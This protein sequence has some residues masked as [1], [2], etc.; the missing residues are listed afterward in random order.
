MP[1]AWG[2]NLARFIMAALLTIAF[3]GTSRGASIEKLLMPGPL[4]AAHAKTEEQCGA[5]HDKT[6][7]ERQRTLCLACHK[8]IAE[9][10]RT[11]TGFHGRMPGAR[12]GQCAGCH[13]EHH[14]RGADVVNLDR[15]SF[16]HDRTNFPLSGAHAA[17]DCSGCHRA[18]SPFRK[19]P[20]AC[21]GCHRTDDAHHGNLG[22]DCKACH[23]ETA[24]QTVSFDHDRTQFPL[25]DKHREVPCSACHA[26]EHYKGTPREC[27]SCHMPDD[28]HRGSRGARCGDCHTEAGWKTAKFDHAKETGFPLLGRHARIGCADCH[29]TGNLKDPLPKTCSGCHA[30]DDHH[31]GR[32]G[33]DCASCHGNELW[34][35]EHYDHAGRHHFELTGAHA[36]LACESCHT[37]VARAQKLP[38]DC[39]GC[40]RADD[41]HGGALGKACDRCHAS[42]RWSE[43]I[44]FDHDLS[45]F[46]LVGLHIV[47]TCA[48]CHASQRFTDAPKD[49]N[50]CHA[51]DDVHKGSLGPQCADCHTPNGWKLWQFDHAAKTRFALTGA[52]ATLRCADC[53]VK[54]A[55]EMK[56]SR[57]CGSCH[58]GDDI[59]DGQFGRHCERCHN[60]ISF[61]GGRAN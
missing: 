43:R 17:V 38:T 32:F 39:A 22:T 4:S 20:V 54:P 16:D 13:S 29:R 8:D 7:R 45:D 26:G 24:W 10:L 52:H 14:G 23:R 36:E 61:R 34:R 18:R 41:V 15:A 48:Q 51:K 3:S 11:G 27:V 59:H 50:G 47:V 53:H 56:L 58:A 35:I 40:H 21:I 37:A 44:R 33:A 6:D 30:S 57:D 42:A 31:A 9:D 25:R 60:S 12:E 46:P 1:E 5:C 2:R 49:C 19:A 55:N 28:V